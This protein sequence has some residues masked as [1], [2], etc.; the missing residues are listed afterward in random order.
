MRYAI[1]QLSVILLKKVADLCKESFLLHNAVLKLSLTSF[2]SFLSCLSLFVSLSL[3]LCLSFYLL[4]L[5]ASSDASKSMDNSE[6]AKSS[7]KE[8]D[9]GLEPRSPKDSN[10]SRSSGYYVAC[11]VE[12]SSTAG[13]IMVLSES[14]LPCFTNIPTKGLIM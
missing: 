3:C 13:W 6:N 11:L 5:N 2:F 1:I 9:Y 14:R 8:V 10:L 12:T 7:D 4:C